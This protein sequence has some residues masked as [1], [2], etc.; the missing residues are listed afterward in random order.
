MSRA[1]KARKVEIA[2]AAEFTVDMPDTKRRY[3]EEE[4]HQLL[5]NLDI[6]GAPSALSIDRGIFFDSADT[7]PVA[8]KLRQFEAWLADALENFRIHQEGLISRIPKPVRSMTMREFQKYGGDVQAASKGL[9]REKLGGGPEAAEVDKL[10]R[11]R[12]WVAS[13]EADAEASG[14]GTSK[15][16]SESSRALKNGE[17]GISAIDSLAILMLR[18]T[19]FTSLSALDG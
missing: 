17:T 14:T 6:E 1:N 18:R 5:A 2:P 16:D 12:K 10:A 9:Q 15:L 7:Y 4:K 3:T 13:Q 11:K 8:H 19:R